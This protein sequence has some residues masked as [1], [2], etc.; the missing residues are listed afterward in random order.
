MRFSLDK[1][2]HHPDNDRKARF[3]VEFSME[4]RDTRK[5]DL[6]AKRLKSFAAFRDHVADVFGILR[7]T[8]MFG[9]PKGLFKVWVVRPAGAF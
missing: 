1:I 9:Q 2:I 4:N 7:W 5:I 8:P 3:T 6:S